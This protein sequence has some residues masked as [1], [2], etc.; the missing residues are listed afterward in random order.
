MKKGNTCAQVCAEVGGVIGK[1]PW[2]NECVCGERRYKE[3]NDA[4]GKIVTDKWGYWSKAK[5]ITTP[6]AK[7]TIAVGKYCYNP[8]SKRDNDSTDVIAAC[9]CQI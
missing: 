7:G 2:G 1:S 8:A 9:Y 4:L 3:A 6:P 5:I